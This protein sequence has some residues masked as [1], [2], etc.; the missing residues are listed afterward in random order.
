MIKF[1]DGKITKEYQLVCERERMA[2]YGYN[3]INNCIEEAYNILDYLK[4]LKGDIRFKVNIGTL[5]VLIVNE[6]ME[7][8]DYDYYSLKI[9]TNTFKIGIGHYS[10]L[11]GKRNDARI[12]RRKLYESSKGYYFIEF[13]YRNYISEYIKL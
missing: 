6:N 10:K 13:G 8:V 11:Y 12:G 2:R 7:Y 4:E 1:K 9:H 5:E 3:N